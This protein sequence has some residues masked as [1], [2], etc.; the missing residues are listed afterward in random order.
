VHAADAGVDELDVRGQ[1]RSRSAAM[2]ATPKP[3][4]ER[5]VLPMPA[6]RTFT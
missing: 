2:T 1:L 3:S 4:S 6:T 5:N